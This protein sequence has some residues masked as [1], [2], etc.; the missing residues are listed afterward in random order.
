MHVEVLTAVRRG[1]NK[2]M[3]VLARIE[4]RK[5]SGRNV[6]AGF[7][8]QSLKPFTKLRGRL[9]SGFGAITPLTHLHTAIYRNQA[10]IRI[11]AEREE[12]TNKEESQQFR[13]GFHRNHFIPESRLSK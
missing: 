12:E 4:M 6:G 7:D 9:L 8:S 1:G 13:E 5:S 2:G 3:D 10:G 11:E